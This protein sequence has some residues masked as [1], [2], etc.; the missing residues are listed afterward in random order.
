[1]EN[2]PADAPLILPEPKSVRWG[3]GFLP[4]ERAEFKIGKDG[5]P[6]GE[7]L[8]VE[9]A[10]MPQEAHDISIS[11][12]G[13]KI[14]AGSGR[15]A[16]LALQTLRQIGMQSGGRG[17]R[18]AEISDAPDLEVRGFMLDIS[19]CK[20]PRL[21]ELSRLVDMLALFKYNRLELYMEHT[22]AFEGHEIVWAGASP[23]SPAAVRKLGEIC[24]VA[25]V[26]LV[27]NMNGLGHMER[28]LRYP[29]YRY[30]AESEAPFVDP[31]GTV[32]KYPTTLYP[33][34]RALDFMDSLYAQLL[35]NFEGE[36]FNIGGDEP[37]E[38]GMGRSRA[39]CEAEGGKYGVYI[40]HMLGL[41]ERA[42]KYGKKVCFWADVLMQSPEYSELLPCDMTPIL[43]GYYLDHPYEEQCSY[44]KGLG[45]DFLVAPG[46][47][48]WNSFG[49]RWDCA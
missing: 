46:T 36:N 13:I 42:A 30:L 18:F 19:R 44:M 9:F 49:S 25:G 5:V 10:D 40:A 2:P 38:L 31:L 35:P 43:W 8:S 47:S 7:F 39:R 14:R 20:V 22:F 24:A 12:V 6:V 29:E 1:M 23:L 34:G 45:R 21:G 41:R 32:R 48:T 17:F 28:W 16:K 15:G 37:W 26:E 4:W 3:D 11:E 33:D 27:P